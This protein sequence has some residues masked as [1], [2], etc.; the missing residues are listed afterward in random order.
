MN[1][2]RSLTRLGAALLAAGTLLLPQVALGAPL[3][4]PPPA[5][6]VDSDLAQQ[7]A[8]SDPN[9]P[10]HVLV[11]AAGT[12]GV[13]GPDGNSRRANDAET[14]VR[15][16][17]GQPTGHINL[18]GGVAADLTPAQIQ[19]LSTD[20]TV[21][22]VALDR[23]VRA[24]SLDTSDSPGAT[25]ITYP[26]TIGAT[27]A[28]RQG[29]T[30]KGIGVAVVDTGIAND[31]AL[32]GHVV[33]RVDFVDPL[34]PTSGDPAGHGTHLAG[35]VAAS[36]P[37]LTGVAPDASLVAVR[38]LDEQGNG[39]LST[40]IKGLEWTVL[41]RHELGIRVV[42]L[43]LS[44]P[45]SGSYL[46]DPLAA[47]AEMAWQSG[48]VVVAAAGNSGP[49]AGTVGTPGIDP[50]ILT[51]GSSDE[52]GTPNVADD[53][54]PWFS[55]HGPTADGIAKPDL[56]TPGRKIVSLRVP[57]STL[58]V[59][60]PTHRE[61]NGLFRLTGTSPSTAVAAG[62]AALVLQQRPDLT[63]DQLKAV[64]TAS[65]HPL[66]G[67]DRSVQGAGSVDVAA[68]LRTATP[69]AQSA[70][71]HVQPAMSVLRYLRTSLEAQGVDVDRLSWDRL[72]WDRLSWDAAAAD[73]LSWDRLSWD[74][75]SWDRLSWDRLSWD[76]LSWD[77][78]SWDRLSWDRLSWD[79][80][81][82]DRLSWDTQA[83][84]D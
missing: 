34:N 26:Q 11:E 44:A 63:P 42:V 71:P 29:V 3:Q 69:N 73:R 43:A 6:R 84:L 60:M 21:A 74:R 33:R 4:S 82:W 2:L 16:T 18:V 67:V 45:A 48:L 14:A 81:S 37:S 64:L 51:V 55:S 65:A 49:A 50:L 31:P 10:L 76:R 35:I 22:H 28:A 58:D 72:S 19:Q 7:L 57:G 25:P 27:L 40:V 9:A 59:Q 75:L 62:A 79:R 68:A 41:H 66:A 78:L 24:T 83:A 53:T 32:R 54:V 12:P 39:R 80:L 13:D 1:R 70:R 36:S 77:R 52:Q 47:A 23:P 20:G 8:S 46:D 56:V 61:P 5:V 15:R 30:G 17:G 38:V